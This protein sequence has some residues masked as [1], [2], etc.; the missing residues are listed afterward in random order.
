[1]YTDGL[2]KLNRSILE[3]GWYNDPNTM[4]L[5]LHLMLKA[6]YTDG[7]FK[8]HIIKRGQLV[9]GRKRLS[10]ELNMSEQEV[11][12]ALNH[13]KSTGEITVNPTSKYSIITLNSYDKYQS[14]T[15]TS[16]DKQPSNSQHSTTN[17]PQYNKGKK[18][19]KARNDDERHASY[20]LEQ[21]ESKSKFKD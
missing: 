4:R 5:F 8:T 2:I 16:T 18:Y 6:N 10:E 13:L 7:E 17:K 14:L 11:R 12:T 1:M 21:F 9:T 15:N 19:N 3:W 20:T